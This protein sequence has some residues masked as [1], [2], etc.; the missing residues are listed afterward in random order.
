M[1]FFF[2]YIEYFNLLSSYVHDSEEKSDIILILFSFLGKVFHIP[3]SPRSLHTASLDSLCNFNMIWPGVVLVFILLGVLWITWICGFVSVI[4]FG[5]F[6]AIIMPD[7][8]S[9][10]SSFFSFWYYYYA[11]VKTFVIAL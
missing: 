1:D 8:S 11:Y 2:Q 10:L 6:S 7:C 9:V 5:I 4:D 3:H